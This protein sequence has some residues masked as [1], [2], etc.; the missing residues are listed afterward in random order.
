MKKIIYK[1]I[2]CAL[3]VLVIFN[4]ASCASGEQPRKPL[5][6]SDVDVWGCPFVEKVLRDLPSSDYASIKTDAVIDIF[7]A[8]GELESGQIV[9]TPKVDVLEYNVTVSNLTL[10]NGD[11]VITS[12]NLQIRKAKYIQV[13][14]NNSL[15]GAPVGYYPDAMLPFSAAVEYQENYINANENQSIYLTVETTLD[16]PVGI[17]TGTLTI[18]FIDF[19]KT[20]PISVKVLDV[21][22]SEEAHLKNCYLATWVSEH[23]EL[24]TTQGMRDSYY[25]ALIDHRLAPSL[26]LKDNDQSDEM[27]SF[28]VDTAF[29]WLSNPKCSNVGI[30]YAETSEEYN[31]AYYKCINKNIFKKYLVKFM[32]KS[33]ETN[34]NLMKKLVFY[35]AVIDEAF[36]MNRPMD[37]V[38]LNY[39]IMN[40]TIQSVVE[41]FESLTVDN[42]EFKSE[43]IESLKV[44]PCILTCEYSEEYIEGCTS[45]DEYIN[46]YCPLYQH[47][48]TEA[49]RAKYD[50]E[51]IVEKWW[52]G[53]NFPRDPYPSTHTDVTDTIPLRVV[54][55]MQ[56]EYGI[57]GNLNWAV[58]YYTFDDSGRNVFVEDYYG[59][60]ADRTQGDGGAAVNG[61][62][63][64]F[65]PG[66]QYGLNSPVASLRIDALRDGI[67]EYEV[68]HALKEKYKELGFSADLLMKNLGAT[69]YS[70]SRVTGENID[71]INA[72]K[73]L[74]ELAEAAN[75][76]AS[77]CIV[78]S[79]DL[80]NGQFRNKIYVNDG[81]ELKNHG[82]LLSDGV[83]YGNGKIY[84]V[85]TNLDNS[86]NT[87]ELTY[88]VNGNEYNYTQNLSG[89]ALCYDAGTLIDSFNSDTAIINKEI[90]SGESFNTEKDLLKLTV[91]GV[92][93]GQQR[94]VFENPIFTH[95]DSKV[96]KISLVVYNANTEDVN[97]AVYTKHAKTAYEMYDEFNLKAGERTVINVSIL[98]VNWVRKGKLNTIRFKFDED[99]VDTVK[100]L[101]V[102]SFLV[103]YN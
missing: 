71:F 59:F 3:S 37:Q 10:E 24:D 67:E 61:D 51:E 86:V 98:G 55:W 87:L 96:N 32:E 31:G 36:L 95:F 103:Y 64:L 54:S 49:G 35:N 94:F 79:T 62:G 44:L 42:E 18:D 34:V 57:V 23:G 39:K 88:K 92:N 45:E 50:K 53:C 11:G 89:K 16:Q 83:Q 72:R 99:G 41:Q 38:R 73:N 100:T 78:E 52:Y 25:Q 13:L 15:N 97:V 93:D 65:Y 91:N 8:K 102:E 4:A 2:T 90:V 21:T 28:Y 85:I 80:A 82:Q 29:K 1:I 48:D 22:V 9:I 19:T 81:V 12:E 7:M 33:L 60:N 58:D 43:L 26:I 70:G 101:L 68:I 14:K 75:S 5:K 84:T 66:G 30:P 20:V 74:Y 27:I 46:C 6:S 77:L 40:T 47:Y 63:Y 56:A 69:L 17:Y 76:N